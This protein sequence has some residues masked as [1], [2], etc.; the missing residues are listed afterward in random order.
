[1]KIQI[2]E[3]SLLTVL[4]LTAILVNAQN[5]NH[6]LVV[7]KGVQ[8]IANKKAFDDQNARKSSIQAKSVAFPAIVVSK[9]VAQSNEQVADGNVE[10]KGYPTWAISKGVARK[11]QEMDRRNSDVKEFPNKNISNDSQP[12]TKK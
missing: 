5:G 8:L 6:P 12:I 9:G 11:N 2:K 3:I 10:S 7:S 4:L 1:M